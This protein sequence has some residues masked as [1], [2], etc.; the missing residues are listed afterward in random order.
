MEASGIIIALVIAAIF[1]Y[2]LYGVIKA[3][4]QAGLRADRLDVELQR[5]R[6]GGPNDA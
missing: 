1:F 4:V 2:V 6:R 3:A 5:Q